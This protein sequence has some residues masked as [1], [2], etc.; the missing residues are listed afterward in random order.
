MRGYFLFHASMVLKSATD[1]KRSLE[2]LT[3]TDFPTISYGDILLVDPAVQPRNL[4]S[5]Y[6]EICPDTSPMF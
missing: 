1:G 3:T 4:S 5:K 6:P 2:L